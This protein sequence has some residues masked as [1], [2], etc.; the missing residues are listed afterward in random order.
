MQATLSLLLEAP[1]S[2]GS[3]TPGVRRSYQTSTTATV[4]STAGDA[5]PSVTDPSPAAPGRLVNGSFALGRPLQVRA[6]TGPLTPL[7]TTASSPVALLAYTAPATN[8]AV[9]IAFRQDIDSTEALRT[10]AY[11]KTLTFTLSDNQAVTPSDSPALRL[12]HPG[13]AE[14][15]TLNA[16]RER[17]GHRRVR[18]SRNGA[19]QLRAV[20]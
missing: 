10:G 20:A 19:V 9:A 8:D 14:P 7:P 2:F 6:N 12:A 15:A 3:F 16:R 17:R 4:T 11:G 18:M 1:A 13:R 5:T